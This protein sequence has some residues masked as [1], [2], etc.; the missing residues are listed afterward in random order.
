MAT[1]S[2][3][4]PE[5]DPVL[6]KNYRRCVDL[7][8]NMSWSVP[9]QFKLVETPINSFLLVGDVL[10]NDMIESKP[11]NSTNL[12]NIPFPL[13]TLGV[14]TSKKSVEV[15]SYKSETEKFQEAASISE[16]SIRGSIVYEGLTW[17]TAMGYNVTDFLVNM[18]EQMKCPENWSGLHPVDPLAC[19]WLLYFGPKSRCSEIA[20]VSEL[21]IG[22]KGPILLPP[23][24]YR[25]DT[26][27][28]SFAHHLCQY[29]KHLY[30]DYE[31][32]ILSCP[33]D[34]TRVKGCLS[35]LR[36][37]AESCVFLSQR[38]LLC[39][40]YKQNAAVSKNILTASDCIILGGSGKSL[41][42]TYMKSYKDP[43]THDSIL[44][45]TYNLEAIVNY[46][47]EHYGHETAGQEI[48]WE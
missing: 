48:N 38:C 44:L 40:L 45:P 27:V 46:I 14:S 28:N 36:Q 30:A 39:H 26:S 23:H 8:I 5:A 21:F 18:L 6:E 42:G 15:T 43:A 32:E 12:V 24:M 22:K 37:V 2:D 35:D 33:L 25:G 1:L 29:V 19:V 34:I 11:V 4:F 3:F 13:S 31:P 20:C 47:L 17:I 9:G 41:L 10:P 16:H 7:A